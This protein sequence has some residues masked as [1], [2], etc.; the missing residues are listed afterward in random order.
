MHRKRRAA[1][2][3]WFSKRSINA[4]EDLI[5]AQAKLLCDSLRGQLKG[6]H[7]AELRV[8]FLAFT[9]DIVSAYVFDGSLGMLKDTRRA[10]EWKR[11]I[12]ALAACVPFVKQFPWIMPIL[13]KIPVK[14][15]QLM[16]PDLARVIVLDQVCAY[17]KD[18]V[19]KPFSCL[20]RFP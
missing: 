1:V 3:P 10:L 19:L 16:V 4:T 14:L 8:N 7:I 11:T 20:E 13:K 5:I 15:L 9:T 2:S 12:S 6:N 18:D 17:P